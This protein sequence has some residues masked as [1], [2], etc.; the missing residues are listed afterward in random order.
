[1]LFYSFEC[2]LSVSDQIVIYAMV[3][4][5]IDNN[6]KGFYERFGFASLNDNS[7]KCIALDGYWVMG[8]KVTQLD[9]QGNFYVII[10]TF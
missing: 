9:N 7:S 5:A 6:T 4:D 10:K 1:M 8:P 3:V 2:T